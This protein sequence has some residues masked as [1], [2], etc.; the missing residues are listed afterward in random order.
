VYSSVVISL[1]LPEWYHLRQTDV[2]M[3]LFHS[4]F[5]KALNAFFLNLCRIRGFCTDALHVLFA[6]L[7]NKFGE[8]TVKN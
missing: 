3:K 2:E 5:M 4:N 8:F 7:E 1:E 6:N